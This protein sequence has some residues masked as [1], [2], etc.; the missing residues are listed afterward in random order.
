MLPVP[1]YLQHKPVFT[2]PYAAHDGIYASSTDVE[3]LSVGLAQ[4]DRASVSVKTMRHTGDQ[5]SPQSEE[6]P[7][8]R[9]V[10]L[11][12]FLAAAL[13]GTGNIPAGTLEHQP[14]DVRVTQSASREPGEMAAF[15]AFVNRNR[16]QLTG[17]LNALAR[18]LDDLRATNRI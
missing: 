3:Y 8:H 15:D 10:D 12:L 7:L 1:E 17:R 6:L 11:T 2:I 18:V 9:A 5:W 16:P 13:F 14:T 4:Y